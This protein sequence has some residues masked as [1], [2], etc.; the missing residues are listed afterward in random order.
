VTNER[1]SDSPEF[2]R[3]VQKVVEAGFAPAIAL[4]DRGYISRD[5]YQALVDLSIDGYIPFKEGLT[6]QSNGHPEYHRKFLEWSRN[7][8]EFD[9]HYNLRAIIESVNHSIKAVFGEPLLSKNAESQSC[10]VLAKIIVYNLR[11]VVY[12]S[13]KLALRSEKCAPPEQPADPESLPLPNLFSRQAAWDRNNQSILR[14]KILPR[15]P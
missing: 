12:W 8:Q 9:V 15:G 13:T 1:G 4:A 7:P 2:V 3:L 6:G 10:E 5:N 11:R 14:N